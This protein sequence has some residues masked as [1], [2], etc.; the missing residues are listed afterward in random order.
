M[1][2]WNTPIK[3]FN[4]LTTRWD[5][6]KR[7]IFDDWTRIDRRILYFWNHWDYSDKSYFSDTRRK[8][9]SDAEIYNLQWSSGCMCVSMHCSCSCEQV[10]NTVWKQICFA[11]LFWKKFVHL[12]LIH[13]DTAGSHAESFVYCRLS[14]LEDFTRV[15]WKQNK[16][17]T[18]NFV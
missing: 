1:S 12:S 9:V 5:E 7:L 13:I 16:K 4:I 15:M 14:K 8:V 11:N 2:S 10:I 18:P 17:F 3:L 6:K